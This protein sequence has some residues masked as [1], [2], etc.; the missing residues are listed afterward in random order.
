MDT[1]PSQKD[2]VLAILGSAAALAGLVLVF[3]GVVIAAYQAFPSNTTSQIPARYRTAATWTLAVF[4]FSLVTVALALAWLLAGGKNTALY[5]VVASTF[6]VQLIA[7][8]T[9]AIRITRSLVD[10]LKWV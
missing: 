9:L 5:V 8:T 2:V 1:A 10:G 7:I 3:L 6:T 4:A